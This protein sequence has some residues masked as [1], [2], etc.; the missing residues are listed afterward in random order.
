MSKQPD[1]YHLRGFYERWSVFEDEKDALGER[2]LAFFEEARKRGFDSKAM[3]AAFRLKRR[4]EEDPAIALAENENVKRYLAALGV[5]AELLSRVAREEE[6]P[7]PE[8]ISPIKA[9]ARAIVESARAKG[10][11][12]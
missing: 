4:C 2:L 9:R 3:R 7:A 12:A 1:L 5:T 11:A 8:K 10:V 6:R